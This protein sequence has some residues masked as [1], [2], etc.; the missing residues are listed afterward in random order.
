MKKLVIALIGLL[1]AGVVYA[2]TWAINWSLYGGY[3][4]SPDSSEKGVLEDYSVTWSL[5]N[6]A[7]DELIDA[8]ATMFAPQGSQI[9][10]DDSSAG[11]GSPTFSLWLDEP[12]GSTLYMGSTTA[13]TVQNVYQYIKIENGT[14]TYE[15]KSAAIP[16]TPATEHQGASA[17]W[18]KIVIGPT[19]ADEVNATWTKVSTPTEVP[20]PATLSLLG[21]GALAMVVR[22]KVRK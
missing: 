20:E 15:W 14:D 6:A 3:A 7:T 9:G 22:R 16:V 21:L 13:T 12:T 11:G 2:N 18:G 1:A 8:G 17:D 10:F 5:M 19:G 4:Y